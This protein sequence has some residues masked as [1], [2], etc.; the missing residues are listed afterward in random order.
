MS[1][2]AMMCLKPSYFANG[3]GLYYVVNSTGRPHYL[4]A[5]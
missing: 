2:S 1:D 3:G 4:D 5:L